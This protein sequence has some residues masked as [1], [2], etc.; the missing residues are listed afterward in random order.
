MSVISPL[1]KGLILAGLVCL[2]VALGW[3]WVQ[4]TRQREGE[5]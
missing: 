5:P 1:E 2:L 4:L 3:Y